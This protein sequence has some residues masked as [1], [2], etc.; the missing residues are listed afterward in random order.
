ML[1]T[2]KNSLEDTQNGHIG[3]MSRTSVGKGC[4]TDFRHCGNFKIISSRNI[5][6]LI[7]CVIFLSALGTVMASPGTTKI[8]NRDWDSCFALQNP[9]QECSDYRLQ[10]DPHG[11]CSAGV[12]RCA[13][14]WTWTQE[15]GLNDDFANNK[16]AGY[17]FCGHAFWGGEAP[18]CSNGVEVEG[19]PFKRDKEGFSDISESFYGIHL[20][21][22]DNADVTVQA[23]SSV[24]SD[25]KY[26]TN[27]DQYQTLENTKGQLVAYL[28]KIINGTL[29]EVVPGRIERAQSRLNE[30][31]ADGNVES[32]SEMSKRG[33]SK[34][35]ARYFT[36]RA[37]DNNK[38]VQYHTCIAGCQRGPHTAR[39]PFPLI[40]TLGT[41]G[42]YGAC[43]SMCAA[44]WAM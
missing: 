8:V 10:T 11:C 27:D 32:V 15:D 44:R 2:N 19:P 23:V 7:Q 26:M 1:K 24:S 38:Y 4:G 35:R 29:P 12:D 34:E 42:F 37:C 22:Q 20:E 30:V 40:V 13:D 9:G 14:V 18:G 25:D 3:L 16:W 31:L 36:Q 28:N 33:I 41:W 17:E 39:A 21:K 6:K 5:M 43:M